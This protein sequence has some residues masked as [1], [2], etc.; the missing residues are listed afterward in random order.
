M[1]IR[2]RKH[3]DRADVRGVEDH[4]SVDH[5]FDAREWALQER[6][7]EEERAPGE[8][9][10]DPD[11][12]AGRGDAATVPGHE[13]GL[14]AYRQVARALRHPLPSHLPADFAAQVAARAVV[15]AARASDGRVELWL[16]RTLIGAFGLSAVVVAARYGGQWLPAILRTLQLDSATAL[17][18]ALALGACVA[19]SSLVEPL[20][21]RIA[22]R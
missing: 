13:A 19:V 11:R 18:W 3:E 9:A 17:N 1:I 2:F 7:F 12:T 22:L 21:R 5:A 14:V 8:R 20:R 15:E 4:A 16:V 6:A 10:L